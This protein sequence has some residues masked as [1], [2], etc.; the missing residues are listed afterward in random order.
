MIYYSV[1]KKASYKEAYSID[2]LT[3]IFIAEN[4]K[5]LSGDRQCEKS[6]VA[7][8]LSSVLKRFFVSSEIDFKIKKT[9]LGKPILIVNGDESLHVSYA[10]SK[11]SVFV[12]VSDQPIGVDVESVNRF[13]NHKGF[14]KWL[15]PNELQY[16]ENLSVLAQIWTRKEALTKLTGL[17]YK[18]TFKKFKL[19]PESHI[20]LEGANVYFHSIVSN[21]EVLSFASFEKNTP[22]VLKKSMI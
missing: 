12:A 2:Q 10:H 9:R 16:K 6:M 21:K 5:R 8:G 4:I 7:L 11:D 15:H 19:Y 1:I 20:F 14:S 22:A 3:A 18:I 17:G 13:E